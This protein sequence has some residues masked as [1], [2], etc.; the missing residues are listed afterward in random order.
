MRIRVRSL[1]WAVAIVALSMAGAIWLQDMRR[2]PWHLFISPIFPALVI[3]VAAA[4]GPHEA[5]GSRLI[6][7]AIFVLAT[8][9]WYAVI[10]VARLIQGPLATSARSGTSRIARGASR[11]PDGGQSRDESQRR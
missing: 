3:V 6:A 10:E 11:D 8:L 9:M 7:P 1:T 4:G 5:S 2:F